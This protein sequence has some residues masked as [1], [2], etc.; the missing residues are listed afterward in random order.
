MNQGQVCSAT[1][2][3]LVHESIKEKLL[4][5][6]VDVAK[7]IKVGNGLDPQNT[8]GPIVSERQW[9]RVRVKLASS[10][11]VARFNIL[12]IFRSMIILTKELQRVQPWSSVVKL[13]ICLDL[14]AKDILCIQ[15]FSIMLHPIWPFGTSY[16]HNCS[17]FIKLITICL[18]GMRKYLVQFFVYGHFPPRMRP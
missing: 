6:L 13:L 7:S 14:W 9:H 17:C 12:C 10:S 16:S 11:L 2:R 1:S 8:M 18:T 15:Q 5:R 3:L 4:E